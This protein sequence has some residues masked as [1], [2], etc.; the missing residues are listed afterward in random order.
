MLNYLPD[1]QSYT[2]LYV[3]GH[4]RSTPY[5]V[6]IFAAYVYRYLKLDRPKFRFPYSK[7]SL[8][9]LIALY[10]LVLMTIQVFY[11]REYDL[12]LSV[13]YTF[14]VRIV[15]AAIVSAFIIVCAINGLFKGK[16]Q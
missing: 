14:A 11:I 16:I 7:T 10:P 4:T 15:F 9:I 12:W 5:F 8:S 13:I 1:D 6:G 3:P 2:A